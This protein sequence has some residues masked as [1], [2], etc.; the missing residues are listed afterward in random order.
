MCRTEEVGKPANGSSTVFFLRR[1]S[2]Q[3]IDYGTDAV[4]F[5][6][7]GVGGSGPDEGAAFGVVVG[8]EV[9]DLLD[10][11]AHVAE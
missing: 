11:L 9:L 7:D 5:F 6:E 2:V 8:D 1:A 3:L 10:Q 4:D